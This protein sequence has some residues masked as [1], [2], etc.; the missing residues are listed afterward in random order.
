MRCRDAVGAL[1]VAA[2]LSAAPSYSQPPELGRLL[3][4]QKRPIAQ[5]MAKAASRAGVSVNLDS[6]TQGSGN[7]A[8]LVIGSISGLEKVPATQ[9]PDG[10]DTAFAYLDLPTGPGGARP[11]VPAGYYTLRVTASQETVDEALKASGGVPPDTTSPAGRPGVPGAEVELIDVH[12]DVVAV[13]P[14]EL[15]VFSPVVPADQISPRTMV[16]PI[17]GARYIIV[18]IICPNGWAVCLRVS[19]IDF[20]TYFF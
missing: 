4:S 9:L 15:A 2:V 20:F 10:V 11:R 3:D 7:G 14:G 13:V 1:V 6:L 16:E 18:W 17:I 12:G 19:W 5:A 8:S